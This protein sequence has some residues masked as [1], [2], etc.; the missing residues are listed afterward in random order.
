MFFFIMNGY[1]NS[2]YVCLNLATLVLFIIN[3][4]KMTVEDNFDK[5]FILVLAFIVSFFLS[6]IICESICFLKLSGNIIL[7]VYSFCF[8]NYFKVW[9]CSISV[10][11]FFIN[12]IDIILCLK[13]TLREEREYHLS[14]IPVQPVIV[15]NVI[16]LNPTEC[17]ICLDDI[18]ENNSGKLE[19]CGHIFHK[20]CIEQWFIVD[21]N[22]RCPLCRHN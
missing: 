6:N 8:D 15:T 11:T 18:T 4:A 3:D 13:R 19:K 16:I 7:T 2:I 1:L 10:T 5:Y 20:N 12:L 17:C 21:P 14:I 9:I 22:L